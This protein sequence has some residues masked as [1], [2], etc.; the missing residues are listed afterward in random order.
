MSFSPSLS[1]KLLVL[2]APSSSTVLTENRPFTY[3]VD[4]STSD[5]TNDVVAVTVT[6]MKGVV[7]TYFPFILPS[8]VYA[9]GYHARGLALARLMG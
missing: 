3:E 4:I 5:A 2:A 7:S 6:A 9:A 1:P 8:S